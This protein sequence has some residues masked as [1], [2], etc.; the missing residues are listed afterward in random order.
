MRCRSYGRQCFII[1]DDET[2]SA[3]LFKKI[4]AQG[5]LTSQV[6][7]QVAHVQLQV[8]HSTPWERAASESAA[9]RSLWPSA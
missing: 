8:Q 9:T 6:I 1:E 2:G 4:C 7:K 3:F 5:D